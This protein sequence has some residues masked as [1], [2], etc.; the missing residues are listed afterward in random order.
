MPQ[1]ECTPISDVTVGILKSFCFSL[2]V[3][4][5]TCDL[6][7]TAHTCPVTLYCAISYLSSQSF[8]QI[9]DKKMRHGSFIE[10][11][12]KRKVTGAEMSMFIELFMGR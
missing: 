2:L 9:K 10:T 1:A 8:L 4:A 3:G 12:G 5:K 7:Y 6:T 11:E